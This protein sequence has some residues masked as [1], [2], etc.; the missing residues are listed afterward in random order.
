VARMILNV[1]G[2]IDWIQVK[3]IKNG[4]ENAQSHILS[5]PNGNIPLEDE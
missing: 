1:K 2:L 5:I 4:I 3:K